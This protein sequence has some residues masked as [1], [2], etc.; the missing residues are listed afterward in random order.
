[1]SIYDYEARFGAADKTTKAMKDAISEGCS[2]Y[3]EADEADY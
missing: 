2:L 3:Y 1:M